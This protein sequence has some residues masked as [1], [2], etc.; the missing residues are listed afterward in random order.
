MSS[1]SIVANAS[2]FGA[3]ARLRAAVACWAIAGLAVAAPGAGA[4]AVRARAPGAASALRRAGAPARARAS[5]PAASAAAVRDTSRSRPVAVA[6]VRSTSLRLAFGTDTLVVEVP[7]TLLR[8]AGI[9]EESAPAAART[10]EPLRLDLAEALALQRRLRAVGGLD[11]FDRRMRAGDEAPQ[12][13]STAIDAAAQWSRDPGLQFGSVGASL[14]IE[15]H[16]ASGLLHG[17]LD[18]RADRFAPRF[19]G[20]TRTRALRWNAAIERHV[21]SRA[22]LGLVAESRSARVEIDRPADAAAAADSTSSNV[23]IATD[24][25]RQERRSVAAG[26][27]WIVLGRRGVGAGGF[28]LRA[29]ALAVRNGPRASD[30]RALLESRRMATQWSASLDVKLGRG[31]LRASSRA[32]R[33]SSEFRGIAVHHELDF[34]VPLSSCTGLT[35][36]VAGGD[37][38]LDGW[39]SGENAIESTSAWSAYVGLSARFGVQ[40]EPSRLSNLR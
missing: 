12:G 17:L 19:A 24:V 22:A 11:E 28:A 23:A 18:V 2:T 3:G 13:L 6:R 26:L 30:W 39:W 35:C 4:S 29:H 8:D 16:V 36:S 38:G 37:P 14:A 25:L 5:A 7:D 9:R 33:C 31:W 40:R 20:A 34:D 27:E 21:G 15:D 32:L 10:H 1:T